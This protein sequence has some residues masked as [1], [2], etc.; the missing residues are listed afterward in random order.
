ML[1]G[2]QVHLQLASIVVAK[3]GRIYFRDAWPSEFDTE[4]DLRDI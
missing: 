3:R 1:G 2:E 4:M